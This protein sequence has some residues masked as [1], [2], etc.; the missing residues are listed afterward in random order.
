MG[1]IEG[2][3]RQQIAL[4]PEALDDYVAADST[5]RIIDEFVAGLDMAALG[6]RR[7]SPAGEGRPGY[8]PRALLALYI[9]GYLNRTR[10][11]RRLEAETHRNLE[12]IWLMRK[13][14][15]DHKTIAE[16]RRVHG[17]TLKQVTRS[18]LLICQELELLDGTLVLIDGTKLRA[19]NSP[20]RTYT[21]SSTAR[22]LRQVEASIAQYLAELDRQDRQEEGM[23]GPTDP[24]LPRKLE[25]LR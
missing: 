25:A 4:F 5:V 19:Q 20:Q 24:D 14:R 12:V 9:Y 16:F 6:F 10:S 7:A 1:Y 23:R 22:L 17:K 18:F 8:D 3:D 21:A 15:P 13:L 2:A 11:S